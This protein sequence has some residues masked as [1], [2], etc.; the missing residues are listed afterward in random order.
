MAVANSQDVTL[1]G[2][3]VA[4]EKGDWKHKN[5]K[6]LVENGGMRIFAFLKRHVFANGARP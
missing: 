5:I 6:R 3:F 1:A 4:G 2:A